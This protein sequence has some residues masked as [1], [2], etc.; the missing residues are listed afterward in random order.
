MT[1]TPELNEQTLIS[2]EEADRRASEA[3]AEYWKE[4]GFD[5]YW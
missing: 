1:D 4:L 3:I 5:G 2:L